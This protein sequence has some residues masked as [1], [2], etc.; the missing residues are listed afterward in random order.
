MLNVPPIA[1]RPP[2]EG[3]RSWGA[4]GVSASIH[5]VILAALIIRSPDYIPDVQPVVESSA[6][7]LAIAPVEMPQF[8][9]PTQPAEQTRVDQ[10]PE[11]V[12]LGPD[13]RNPDV[14][15][16]RER[17]PVEP[18]PEINPPAAPE[19]AEAEAPTAEPAPAPTRVVAR[20]PTAF[21]YNAYAMS[22]VRPPTTVFESGAGEPEGTTRAKPA[23]RVVSVGSN[24]R[25][26][27]SSAPDSRDWRP[28]FPDAAGRCVDIPDLG[29]NADGSPVLAS[30]LG[31]VYEADGRTPLVGAHL[32]IVGT[33]FVTFSNRAGDYRLE[34]DP[35]LLERCR[36]QYVRVS[37]EGYAGRMLTLSIG[38]KIRSDDVLLRRRS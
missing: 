10:P 24:G 15:I 1:V 36:V 23:E 25:V 2:I 22:R 16:P 29:R 19:R 14:A 20:I 28:S 31:R 18:E 33:A 27:E 11:A 21:D 30:V 13:S 38:Q 34:F 9:Q 17:G 5:A 6:A 26:G 7:T 32:Q 4:L 35:K 37:A 3:S 12:P 8:E